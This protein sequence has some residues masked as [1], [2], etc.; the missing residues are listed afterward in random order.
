M[1]RLFL[2]EIIGFAHDVSELRTDK[3]VQYYTT[4]L[5]SPDKNYRTVSYRKVLKDVKMKVKMT[6]VK[7]KP[8]YFD[9]TK[10]DIEVTNH[11][12]LEILEES[13]VEF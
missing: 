13:D 11:K 6:A 5:Q 9:K 7:R 2:E 4:M 10:T 3:T 1:I 12:A 8:N